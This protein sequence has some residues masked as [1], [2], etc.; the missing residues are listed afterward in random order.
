MIRSVARMQPS[1]PA[2][3]RAEHDRLRAARSALSW[4]T[5]VT[6]TG[7]DDGKQ[8]GLQRSLLGRP[9]GAGSRPIA[10][11]RL[12]AHS[13]EGARERIFACVANRVGD[14]GDRIVSCPKALGGEVYAPAR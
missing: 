4:R 1:F 7:I 3:R 2:Q 10:A 11:G 14:D 5:S 8:L 9:S 13:A 12:S 6:P